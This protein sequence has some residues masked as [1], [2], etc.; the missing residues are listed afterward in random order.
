MS[1]KPEHSS[2]AL[3]PT[4]ALAGH[5]RGLVSKPMLGTS[6]IISE[7]FSGNIFL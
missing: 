6:D 7:K 5:G 4:I 1:P 2:V 3:S